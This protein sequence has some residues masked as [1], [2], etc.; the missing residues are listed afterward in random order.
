MRTRLGEGRVAER[1]R[2]ETVVFQVRPVHNSH[3]VSADARS[4]H[5]TGCSMP[6][7]L[8]SLRILFNELTRRKVVR[9]A[10]AYGVAAGAIMQVSSV[11]VP[12]LY[13]PEM[14]LTV[15]VVL[16]MAGLP[17]AV[18]LSWF[19]DITPA[20]AVAAGSAAS[21]EPEE[22][23]RR[24]QRS[25][26]TLP[27][28]A[29]PFI[30]REAELGELREMLHERRARFITITGM[31][32]VGKTRLALR[33]AEEAAPGFRHGVVRMGLSSL[34]SAELLP[35][36]LLEG[37]ALTASRR[38][39]P[40]AEVIDFL[41]EKQMLLVLDNFEQLISGGTV[42]ATILEQAPGVCLVV[43]SRERVGLQAEVLLALDGLALEDAAGAE[44]GDAVRLFMSVADRLERTACDGA[45]DEIRQ[46]CELLGGVPLAIELAAS[47][48]RVMSCSE[49][50]HEL[51]QGLDI[52]ATDAP[53]V[54]GRHRSLRATFD[55]SWRLLTPEERTAAARLAVFLTGFDR[56]AA[57]EV[58]RADTALL[59]ALLDKS[60]LARSGSRF[61]MLDVV[62]QY[63]LDRLR[64]T[65]AEERDARARHMEYH[66]DLVEAVEARAVRS[67]PAALAELA[68][69]IYE[70][71]AAWAYATACTDV[72]VLLRMVNPLYHFYE[73]R[74]WAREGVDAFGQALE[75][76]RAVPVGSDA[77]AREL[78]ALRGMLE[79]RCGALWNRLG[80]LDRAEYLLARGL[81]AA[82]LAGELVEQVFA[83]QKLG[84]NLLATS[85][86]AGAADAQQRALAL[87]RETGDRHAI[88]WSIAQL[89]NVELTRGAHDRAASL[90]VEALTLLRE[91][92]DRGGVLAVLNNL[93][94]IAYDQGDHLE[95][96]R[97][98]SDALEVQGDQ[99]NRRS[100]A[101][102][103]HNLG[104]A[105]RQL[106]EPALAE[107][108]LRQ[109]VEISEEM[110]YQS[111]AVL[112]HAGMAE[113]LLAVDD[114]AGA[115]TALDC[116]LRSAIA[117]RNPRV[118]LQALGITAHLRL[119]MGDRDA[120]GR[121]AAV[122]AAHPA[123]GED[124]RRYAL[125]LLEGMDLPASD[126]DV[127]VQADLSSMA[128]Q[129]LSE[130]QPGR[131]QLAAG[132]PS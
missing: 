50:L 45:A 48:V 100:A 128:S 80:E 124:A 87:A 85:D 73:A 82:E 60:L 56:A 46:I 61:L 120:A 47:W 33:L 49:I 28:P 69:A 95:A 83:L 65:P 36:A 115:R 13:L 93:G 1:V 84:A 14:V 131:V 29:T 4:P 26:G 63:A 112:A 30:G 3:G 8:Q 32:G 17:A 81:R 27:V 42:L 123:S 66:A 38:E 130:D 102:L 113:L 103:L 23:R 59:R 77:A 108:Y 110:G 86:H 117:T 7:R 94:V 24:D 104:S 34:S 107:Q 58:G 74:G 125:D 89:G 132:H 109:A 68:S 41:R 10:V 111:I 129:L 105:T 127:D 76:L 31:G 16:S 53:D 43:T 98:F 122:V 51:Q 72:P 11:V 57:E 15:V 119:R 35:A 92:G 22:A 118:L 55:G 88:G 78:A 20:T 96:R 39:E 114:V 79:V 90:Y 99:D 62:R 97:R 12:A 6:K 71:R 75:L 52:L 2:P 116:A 40:L 37:F 101:M 70:L 25:A 9:T 64:E 21:V 5:Q 18:L 121:L 126:V 106:G 91:D 67:D 44:P 19:Y 54:P